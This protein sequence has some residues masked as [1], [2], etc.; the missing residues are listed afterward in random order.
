MRKGA[1]QPVTTGRPSPSETRESRGRPRASVHPQSSPPPH[2]NDSQSQ[3]ETHD[4]VSTVEQISAS[5]LRSLIH[6]ST[7]SIGCIAFDHP[8]DC[9]LTPEE[10]TR[11]IYAT[12]S[13]CLEGNLQFAGFIGSS[14]PE[15]LIG[16]TLSTI[17][18]R[19]RRFT[20]MF[21]VWHRHKLSGQGFEFEAI[22]R[23]DRSIVLQAAIYGHIHQE[24]LY[25]MWIILRDVTTV[26]RAISALSKSQ[27]HYRALFNTP[28][29]LFIRVL[30]DGTIEHATPSTVAHLAI[31]D[32]HPLTIDQ[33]LERRVHPS[34][35]PKLDAMREHRRSGLSHIF[36]T[37]LCLLQGDTTYSDFLVRQIA[38]VNSSGELDYYDILGFEKSSSTSPNVSIA[39]MFHDLNNHLVVARANLEMS[40]AHLPPDGAARGL[41]ESALSAI[42]D[43]GTYATRA[44][45]SARHQHLHPEPIDVSELL[46][47]M[48]TLIR[49]MLSPGTS[50]RKGEISSDATVFADPVDLK[51]ILTNLIFN[52]QEALGTGGEIV[53]SATGSD[54]KVALSIS[55]NGPGIPQEALP[56]LFSAFV[57]TKSGDRPRGLGLTTV[58]TLVEANRGTVDVTSCPGS[59][60][61]FTISLPMGSISDTTQ[62]PN[63]SHSHSPSRS[64]PTSILVADD[65]ADVRYTVTMALTHRGYQ[66]VAVPDIP[67]LLHELRSSRPQFHVV[68]IDRG[69]MRPASG[70][71]LGELTSLMNHIPCIITS[72][73]P[74]TI[75][76]PALGFGPT[77]F[78]AKPFALA[79]LYSSIEEVSSELSALRS[80]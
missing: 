51:R 33:V 14:S 77:R 7:A 72:G 16:K 69:L 38:H 73:D 11:D 59:G 18:P 46:S 31:P 75:E 50:I 24:K 56:H 6:V 10:F 42:S 76:T 27:K 36:E 47:G 57:S 79:T 26:T 58:K 1:S 54:T 13:R 35:R 20:E 74:T 43:S 22:D 45:S 65:Q 78:L 41:I 67:S 32:T 21:S 17:L 61:I 49:P 39:G 2:D 52:A 70:E 12:S 37:P 23:D 48:I 34:D 62:P 63:E 4:S 29:I 64:V 25:R 9:S 68:I 5:D 80:R 8:I 66:A 15:Q 3:S 40:L 71:A 19:H 28:G 55:D 30:S 60:T 53:L 44:L